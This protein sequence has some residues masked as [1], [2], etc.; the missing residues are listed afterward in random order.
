MIVAALASLATRLGLAAILLFAAIPKLT[1]ATAFAAALAR[2]RLLP[3]VLVAPAAWLL[4]AL[5]IVVALA[6]LLGRRAWLGA[7]WLLAAGLATAFLVGVASAWARGLDIACGCF[8]N[9]SSIAFRDVLLRML[10]LIVTLLGLFHHLR[11]P[12]RDDPRSAPR[13]E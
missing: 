1:D 12:P 5:E 2:Y 7:A 8:G 6:L 10:L 3:E 11:T 9:G 13:P 4:P